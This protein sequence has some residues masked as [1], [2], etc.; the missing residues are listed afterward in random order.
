MHRPSSLDSAVL[1]D[2]IFDLLA[3]FR[4]ESSDSSVVAARS[5]E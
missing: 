4:G 5:S 3:D 1:S 2:D